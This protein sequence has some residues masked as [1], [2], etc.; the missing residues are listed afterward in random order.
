MS[1]NAIETIID[2]DVHQRIANIKDLY[3][4]LSAARKRDIEAFGLR[5][6]S[7]GYLNGGDRGYRHDSWPSDGAMVGSD[8]DLACGNSCW[9][10]IRSSTRSCSA[11]SFGRWERCRTLITPPIWHAPTTSG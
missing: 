6:P 10:P 3:P 1:T 5:F 9:T 4:Y 2:C 7:P 11:R 8:L